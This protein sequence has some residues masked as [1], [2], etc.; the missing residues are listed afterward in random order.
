MNRKKF[1]IICLFFIFL[2]TGIVL[3]KLKP[4]NQGLYKV[5]ILPTLGGD[6]T[7]PKSINDKGQVAGYSETA[8]GDFHL[9]IWD[10]ESGIKDLG[11][12]DAGDICIN[13]KSQISANTRNSNGNPYS[14]IFDPDTGKTSLP[15][16]GGKITR[17]TGINN[18]GQVI[19][20]SDTSSGVSHAFIWDKINGI[21]DLTPASPND[22]YVYSINDSGQVVAEDMNTLLIE[23]DKELKV[24]SL[25]ITL[26]G[27]K[28]QINYNGNITG[29][30]HS[31]PNKNYFISWNKNSG[32]NTLF[33]SN[34]V[35]LHKINE[36]N[37][38]I[39]TFGKEELF[40]G[41]FPYYRFD[42]YMLDPKIGLI[43]LDGYV[44]LRK[45]K[46]YLALKDIN[47]KGDIIGYINSTKGSKGVGILFEPIPEK[48]NVMPKQQ[49]KQ[50]NIVFE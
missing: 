42:N 12:S 25:Q 20:Y 3:L 16:L 28:P 9:F 24:T 45:M 21:R 1:F 43:S 35:Y 46:D 27:G 10:K 4:R 44:P 15:T 8:S 47:N 23:T 13:N 38:L 37:Q 7:Y 6:S 18:H 22:T 14:F 30:L 39:L 11:P 32:Q 36:H 26:W 31:G 49:I 50:D 34:L 48:M 19:G 5:T 33:R 29:M 40:L 2:I 41:R 17:A